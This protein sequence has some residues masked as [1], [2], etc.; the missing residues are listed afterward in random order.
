MAFIVVTLVID[1]LGIG[2]IVPVLPELVKHLV[3]GDVATAGRYVGVI[4]SSYALAQFFFAP[5]LGALS[6]RFG[7]RPVL[8][9]SLA[10]LSVDYV[11]QGLAPSIAWLF[12]GRLLAGMLGGSISTANAYIA[13]V[14]TPAN[15]ARNYGLVGVSFGIGFIFGPA[16][17]GLLGSVHLRLPFFVSAGLAALN[18]LYG[19][20]VLPESLAPEHRSAF[21]RGKLN[22][23]GSLGRLRR[24][25]LVAGLAVAFMLL[26]LAQRG[27]E[28]VWVLYTGYRFGWSERQNGLTLALVGLV[29][30]VVQGFLVRPVIRRI[31]ERSAVQLGLLVASLAFVGYG[32]AWSGRLMLV[33]ILFGGLAGIAG[34]SIQALVAGAVPRSE[35]GR[36]QGSLTSLM[37]LSSILSP[38]VFTAGL[39]SFF[40]SDAAPVR[41]PGAPFFL[42]SLLFL[43]AL[44]VVRRV[45]RRL[46][47]PPAERPAA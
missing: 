45:F 13:D 8:L 43:A 4:A 33:V 6:D 44:G 37:S 25:P 27:L 5:V 36:V 47:E 31:G 10:G 28:N 42:G 23:F 19:F 3:G 38:L 17:G 35:Q 14:S 24:Y 34:P 29:A 11:I 21:D 46:P 32:S 12:V 9:L 1:I 41:L 15:R 7:R 39:F 2:I 22:P 30:V 16:L 40:T 26:S 20:F 18:W